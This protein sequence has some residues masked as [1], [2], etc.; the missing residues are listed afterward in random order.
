[1]SKSH[2][3]SNAKVSAAFM[4]EVGAAE[5]QDGNGFIELIRNHLQIR[6][7]VVLKVLRNE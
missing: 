4:V 2:F 5:S 3:V 7:N 1:M 6:M